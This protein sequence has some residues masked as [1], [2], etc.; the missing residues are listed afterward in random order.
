M[1]SNVV[2]EPSLNIILWAFGVGFLSSFT[3]CVFPLIPV[4]LSLFG[5]HKDTPPL[6]RFL[7][8]LSYVFGIAVTYTVLGMASA[9]AGVIFGS[10]LGSLWVVLIICIFLSILALFTLEILNFTFLNRL[11]TSASKIGGSGFLGAFLMGTA[12]GVV[13]APCVGPA[14]VLV[15]GIAAA[16]KSV[17]WGASLL[18][19]YS[20]GL[21]MIFLVLGTF[22]GLLN[23]LPRAGNW[24]NSVKFVIASAL[25]MVVLFLAQPFLKQYY[26]IAVLNSNLLLLIALQNLSIYLG[27]CA[28][29]KDIKYLKVIGAFLL[30]FSLYH[31]VF[32]SPNDKLNTVANSE[33]GQLTWHDKY[34]QALKIGQQE[35]KI[36]MLDLYA[37]WCAA[38]LEFEKITFADSMVKKTLSN[39]VLARI[40]F[41]DSESSDAIKLSEIYHV[42][43]LPCILFISPKSGALDGIVPEIP[44]SRIT[45]F[46]GPKEFSDHLNKILLNN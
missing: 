14:L 8:S 11:Q 3:P 1:D 17:L 34:E 23:T 39:F 42:P 20:L 36:V 9:K 7:L 4:T 29:R 25:F 46:V 31:A 35:N 45:G 32:L 37:D 19:A 13:A 16:S 5:A 40:D 24:L 27:W 28:Y 12:S 15:L 21:G 33:V 38:C 22:S 2:V 26:P 18:F 44:N 41:T 6:K 30:A 10:L 43:G